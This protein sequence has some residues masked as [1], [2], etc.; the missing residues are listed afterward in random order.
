MKPYVVAA[1]RDARG[2][3]KTTVPQPAL[4]TIGERVVDEE[5]PLLEGVVSAERGSGYLARIPGYRIAGKTGTGDIAKEN[6]SGYYLDRINHTFVGFGPVSDPKLIILT[7]L[8]DPKG[9]RYAEA[10]AVPLFRK[11]MKFCLDYYAIPTDAVPSV[12]P[13]PSP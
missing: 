9:V 6:G 4:R 7:R 5:V 2:K 10:T 8:E 13:A 1:I 12:T 11:I 3:L